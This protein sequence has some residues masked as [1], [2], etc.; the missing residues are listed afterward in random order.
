LGDDSDGIPILS[1]NN[2]VLDKKFKTDLKGVQSASFEETQPTRTGLQLSEPNLINFGFRFFNK[3]KTVWD[4]DGKKI[5]VL[6][7]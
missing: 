1:V 6:E 7:K 3:Y 4:F 2:I 5:Y